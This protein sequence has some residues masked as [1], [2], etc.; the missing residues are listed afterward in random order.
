MRFVLVLY[1]IAIFA[2]FCG[3]LPVQS[4]RRFLSLNSFIHIPKTGGSTIESIASEYNFS[5]GLRYGDKYQITDEKNI[6]PISVGYRYNHCSW[7]HVP[8]VYLDHSHI[9]RHYFKGK[10][11]FCFFRDPHAR[12]VSEYK[13]R[14]VTRHTNKTTCV[15]DKM[16]RFLSDKLLRYNLSVSSPFYY[17]DDCHWI[18][19]HVYMQTC[20]LVIKTTYIDKWLQLMFNIAK[21][22]KSKSKKY[23]PLTKDD[24][25][26][27]VKM[28][29]NKIYKTD[30]RRYYS[31][32]RPT[33]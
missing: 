14:F 23:C 1:F 6:I 20:D 30:R 4:F 7:G 11:T 33:Q 10:K 2:S 27:G 25:S 21:R 17:M 13:W 29:A 16:N 5:I 3:A 19:Q 8:P 28:I 9:S 24:L 32:M 12:L 31:N 18:P 15:K 22:S 26:H